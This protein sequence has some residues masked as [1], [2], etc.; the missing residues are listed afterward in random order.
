MWRH[1]R[2]RPEACAVHSP[3]T[4]ESLTYRQLWARSE[5]VAAGLALR[6]V[7][8]GEVVAVDLGRSVD[9]V[10]ALLGVVRAGGAY[11]PLD[12]HAPAE[13]RALLLEEAGVR[14]TLTA[15]DLEDTGARE[16]EDRAVDGT[17][18]DAAYVD[19]ADV[20][21]TVP[22][23]TD[24]RAAGDDPCY[25]NFTSGSTGRPKG[26]VVPHRAVVRL[27]SNAR[28]CTVEPGDRVANAS[29]PAFDATTFE[30]WHTLTAGAAVV[31]FPAVTELRLDD[32][33]ELVRT[34]GITTM[35]LTT[36]LFHMVARERP[37][38][39]RDL[40]T[41]VVG[42]EQ[43][44]LAA[45]L[46]VL[47]EGPPGRLVN[48]Y[49]PTETTTFATYYD[50]TPDSLAGRDRV[51]VGFPLQDT[52]VHVLDAE[53]RPVEP[54]ATGEL[55]VGG[56]GVALGY[57]N[58]PDLTRERFVP[59][60]DGDGPVYRT[61][62]LA[63]VLPDGALEVLGRRDRQVKLRGFRIELEE[64]ERAVLATGL[65]DSAFA[66]KLG[67]GPSAYLACAVLPVPGA[68][69]GDAAGLPAALEGALARSLPAYVVPTRW[70]V[71]GGLP[72][73]PTGK[74]D[75]AALFAPL[76]SPA[77]EDGEIPGEGVSTTGE[78]APISV[79]GQVELV[80]KDVLGVPAAAPRDN[81]FDVGGNSILAIQLASRL[82]ERL[83]VDV[84]PTDVLLAESLA[85]LADRVGERVSAKP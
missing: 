64:V 31:V 17:D 78:P 6:G 59:V 26:V 80:W 73:G 3:G 51:P 33:A 53:L 52:P 84:E 76:R 13:R 79:A 7:E 19:A 1:V 24:V 34:E 67:E 12:A 65:V 10:V 8:R 56:P 39:F 72:Y 11:L 55:C 60:P 38:A 63:R 62:D 32:W 74:V 75:R 83:A 27:V 5:R 36:S 20:D 68:D 2:V 37:G 23:G 14:T 46:R 57:L 66:E 42:G 43:L 16:D 15:A 45:C 71:L 25:V 70:H 48:G 85:E 30:V 28:Y 9:L 41:V 54:G 77:E 58:R 29:N 82:R 4:G 35:F 47:A 21:G 49:G 69:P 22:R 61:G 81:F 40:R 50:C 44:D 18:V